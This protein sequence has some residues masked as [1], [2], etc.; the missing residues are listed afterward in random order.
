MCTGHYDEECAAADMSGASTASA[1]AC[2]AVH[3]HGTT[4][5]ACSYNTA[6]CVVTVAGVDTDTSACAAVTGTDLDD[7]V[8][9]H[10]VRTAADAT[11]A[12][13]TYTADTCTATHE[14][15]C[16]A[17]DLTGDET[18][19]RASCYAT[20]DGST[21]T[22]TGTPD[23][24]ALACPS[25]NQA[26]NCDATTAWLAADSLGRTDPNVC[27]AGSNTAGCV[28][29]PGNVA[30]CDYFAF[31][32]MLMSADSAAVRVGVPL[33]TAA[34]DAGSSN[35]QTRGAVQAG[36]VTATTT[37]TSPRVEATV[38]V[39]TPLLLGGAADPNTIAVGGDSAFTLKRADATSG[40]GTD[41]I[42][43]GQQGATT[44]DNG[45]DLVIK[46][47][48]KTGSGT[49]GSVIMSDSAGTAVVTVSATGVTV[50]QPLTAQAVSSTS[51]LT[52]TGTV[53]AN[54]VTVAGKTEATTLVAT[55][56]LATPSIV[57][58]ANRLDMGGDDAFVISKPEHS[59]GLCTVP[60]GLPTADYAN[61]HGVTATCAAT[62]TDA[63]ALHNLQAAC[64]DSTDTLACTWTGSAC[65]ATDLAACAAVAVEA[66]EATGDGTHKCTYNNVVTF[67]TELET[68]IANNAATI[69]T[70]HGCELFDVVSTAAAADRPRQANLVN[71]WSA[72]AP[73]ASTCSAFTTQDDC[74]AGSAGSARGCGFSATCTGTATTAV[75]GTTDCPTI[76][77]ASIT[78]D[79]AAGNHPDRSPGACPAGCTHAP[80][81][82]PTSCVVTT[83]GVGV[84]Y[85]DACR[86]FPGFTF[87]EQSGTNKCFDFSNTG[88]ADQ[89]GFV[90][91]QTACT[92]TH[93]GRA[94]A[95]GAGTDLVLQG[96]AA[97]GA[98]D[99]AGGSVVLKPGAAASGGSEG[100]VQFQDSDG[101]VIMDVSKDASGTGTVLIQSGKSLSVEG[102]LESAGIYVA[103]PA[104]SV[105]DINAHGDAISGPKVLDANGNLQYA[106][107]TREFIV[108][109]CDNGNAD[110]RDVLNPVF[111]TGTNGQI[112]HVINVG[113]DYCQM[114]RGGPSQ[115][116]FDARFRLIGNANKI[117]LKSSADGGGIIS[118]MYY[119]AN[120]VGGWQQLT[121]GPTE[122]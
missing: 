64:E 37:V 70:R 24:Q 110:M 81:C 103:E 120:G 3:R 33:T 42:I 104:A 67:P 65:E 46:P 80:D 43:Q 95:D 17:A 56:S 6:T 32:T 94:W 98:V 10:A 20:R 8:A 36:T 71:T 100:S 107:V 26:C 99:A 62:D 9:C 44:S 105:V 113:E 51:T 13:C 35:I 54:A 21:A 39:Q 66:T 55:T 5:T 77:A 119:Y 78:A 50:A 93:T 19:A 29:N 58:T 41:F 2:A 88:G 4:D 90:L 47:G 49:E 109:K 108:L 112:V 73:P 97:G 1:T 61:L 63:C 11:V 53:T 31:G 27:G 30:D 121:T 28:H 12:A 23:A 91:H 115:A 89:S 86:A 74:E 15:F 106:P 102:T 101:G 52:T 7:S 114:Q 48:A 84:S 96:Q 59:D 79:I 38:H 68:Y 82:A 69:S 72:P 111:P 117:C 116:N 22:C 118:F 45:G 18:A 85:E 57:P 25:D 76:F 122:C 14:P 34:I 75:G 16:A 83:T 92:T 87:R 40:A 60:A